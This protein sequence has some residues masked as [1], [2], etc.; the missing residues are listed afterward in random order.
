MGQ[1]RGYLLLN[2]KARRTPPPSF[3]LPGSILADPNGAVYL[4]IWGHEVAV[5]D[6]AVGRPWSGCCHGGGGGSGGIVF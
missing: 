5:D 2:A 3:P 4:V 1:Q 6:P